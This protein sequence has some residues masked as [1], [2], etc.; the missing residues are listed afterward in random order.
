[1]SILWN[2]VMYVSVMYV[3]DQFVFEN[4]PNHNI[5]K[6][7]HILLWIKHSYTV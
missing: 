1:M 4:W 6:I 3:T 7:T 5:Y 2:T